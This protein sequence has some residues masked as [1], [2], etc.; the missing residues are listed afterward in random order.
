[1]NNLGI[2]ADFSFEILNIIIAGTLASATIAWW[3]WIVH[4]SLGQLRNNQIGFVDLLFECF[5]SLCV[6]LVILTLIAF[7]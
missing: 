5:R 1:M 4:C 3:I 7:V 6:V 2:A